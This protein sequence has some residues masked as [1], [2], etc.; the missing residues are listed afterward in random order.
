[1]LEPAINQRRNAVAETR[2][3]VRRDMSVSAASEQHQTGTMSA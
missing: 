1:M 3:K 2:G